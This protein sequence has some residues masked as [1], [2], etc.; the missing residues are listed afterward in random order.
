[1]HVYPLLAV[2]HISLL[3]FRLFC[4]TPFVLLILSSILGRLFR[5]LIEIYHRRVYLLLP[6]GLNLAAVCIIL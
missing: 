5:G 6:E 2:E 3:L 1:M 4:C